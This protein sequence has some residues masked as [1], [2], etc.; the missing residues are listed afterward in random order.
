VR[1]YAEAGATWWIE[2]NWNAATVRSVRRRVKA[3]PAG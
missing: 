3:G 2:A 1:P